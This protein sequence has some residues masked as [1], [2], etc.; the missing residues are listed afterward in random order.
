MKCWIEKTNEKTEEKTQNIGRNRNS[1]TVVPEVLNKLLKNIPKSVVQKQ[2]FWE[3][4]VIL[5][6]G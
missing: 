6:P 3:F 5:K 1:I 4:L 2:N